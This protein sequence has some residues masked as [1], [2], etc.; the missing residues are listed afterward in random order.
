M[1]DTDSDEEARLLEYRKQVTAELSRRGERVR[2]IEQEIA[3]RSLVLEESQRHRMVL[4]GDSQRLLARESYRASVRKAIER[5]KGERTEAREDLKRAQDR[6][7]QVDE[8]LAE[9][10]AQRSNMDAGGAKIEPAESSGG[11]LKTE[12]VTDREDQE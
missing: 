8:D 1:K 10:M 7:Q 12:S 5:L 4:T 9:C 3:S 11:E 2:A 6:L